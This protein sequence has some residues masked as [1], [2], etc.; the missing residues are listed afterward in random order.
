MVYKRIGEVLIA[1]GYITEQQLME[2]LKIQKQSGGKKL[3]DVLVDSGFIRQDQLYQALERQLGVEFID[4]GSAEIPK[5]MARQ[6]PRS[7][8]EKYQV[9]PVS[10]RSGYLSIAIADPLNFPAIDAVR[11]ASKKKII[12]MLA[13]S[14]SIIRAIANLYGSES[15]EKALEDLQST[16][17]ENPVEDFETIATANVIGA[18]SENAAPTIRLVNS[19]L[20]Y[21]VSQNS[22]DIHME[23]RESAY[24]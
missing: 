23:P 18:D 10:E 2:A 3:G 13:T 4:L 11:M 9:L 24:G 15:A 19:F 1:G 7:L 12:P 22:S 6:F 17:E 5:E 21:A 8:A 20:E 16:A 14:E